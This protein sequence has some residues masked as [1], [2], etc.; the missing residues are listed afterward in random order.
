MNNKIKAVIW[1]MGGVILRTE[2]QNPRLQLAEKYDLPLDEIYRL[3][4]GGETNHQASIGKITAGEH[5]QAVG[6]NLGIDGESLREF[7]KMFWSGDRVDQELLDYIRNLPKRSLKTALLSNAWT[8]A[9]RAL[10]EVHRCIDAFQTVVF[11]AEV[12]LAKP[13]SGIYLKTLDL[14]GVAPEEAIF[15]D[16]RL[17]NIDAANDL[18]IRG[19]QFKDSIQARRAVDELLS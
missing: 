9:R 10:T 17:E 14:I 3:V 18:G 6:K 5:W 13:D 1:D 15:V 11:S 2:D 19:V 4:F 8:D 12:G 16:D 7:E